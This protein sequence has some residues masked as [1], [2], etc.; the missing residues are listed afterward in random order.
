M[1]FC[2][3]FSRGPA[4]SLPLF[5]DMRLHP[6]IF[7]WTVVIGALGITLENVKEEDSCIIECRGSSQVNFHTGHRYI[8][9]YSTSTST[10]L[11]GSPYGRSGI[12][13]ESIVNIEALGKCH[14][15]LKLQDVQLKTTLASREELVKKMETL[16]KT[17]ERYLLPFSFLD[18]NITK[19]CP[20]TYEEIWAL[21]IKRGILSVLQSSLKA[22]T[23]GTVEE[24]DVLG[25][26]P[27]KYLLK[28]SI[29]KKTKDLNLCSH[30]S[31]SRSSLWSVPLPDGAAQQH[32][33]ES[34]LE[35]IQSLKDKIPVQIACTET[36]LFTPFSKRGNGAKTQ[37]HSSLK[38]LKT[39][40]T[41]SSYMKDIGEVYVSNLLYE[42]EE[43]VVKS[44]GEEVAETVRNLC[45]AQS[46]HF[47]TADL[48]MKL[49]F[50]LRHLSADAMMDL[51]QTSSFKCR[52]NWQPLID[53]LP[54]CGTEACVS[55]MKE[56]LLSKEVEEDQVESF[57]WSLSFI[58]QPTSGMIGS[59]APLLQSPEA[60]QG[61]FLGVTALVHNFCS[62]HSDCALVPELQ[63]VM[64]TLQGYLKKNC[65]IQ[66]PELMT[67]LNLVL[68]A[69]GNAGLAAASLSPV[70]SS[71]A[72]L[73]SNPL[74]IRVAA[75]EAFR[76]IPCSADRT[77]LLQ[78]Y[79]ATEENAELRISSY[80]TAMKCPSEDLFNKVQQ[81]L[82]DEKSSQV[83]SFVWSHL[84]ELLET[85]DPLKA[86]LRDSLPD[87]ILSKE[88]DW[89][90]WKYSS[91]SD[92]TFRAASGGANME[93]SV[94]FTPA[95][96]IPRSAM[97]NLT[98]HVMGRAINLLEV[99]I[100]LENAETLIKKLFGHRSAVHEY[101]SM[102]SEDGYTKSDSP[103][104]GTSKANEKEKKH[105]MRHYGPVSDKLKS[106]TTK[107]ICPSGKYN[108]MNDLE[109]KFAKGMGSKKELKCGLSLKIFGNELRF[110]DCED[111]RAEV[112]RHSLNLA[113]LTLKFLKGQE[114]QYSKR[115][116][117]ATE[118]LS[119][120]AISGFPVQLSLIAS[121]ATK[122]KIKGN[123]DFKRQS[124][125]YI[126]GYIKPSALIQI[127]AQ[128]GV[129]GALGQAGLKWVTR[130]RTS[131]SLDGGVQVKKGRELKV[132]LNTPEESMEIIDFS[133]KLYLVSLVGTERKIDL[134][135]DC[136]ETKTCTS[137]EVSKLLG[138]QFCSEMSYPRSVSGLS[139]PL[140]G[141][142][143]AMLILRK[144][145]K[146]LQQFLL[147][148]RYN[149]IPQ[150]D[151][152]I[153]NEAVLHFFV[154]TPKSYLKREIGVDLIF[155]VP[156]KKFRIQLVHPRKKIQMEGK[157]EAS[158]NS[159]IGHLEL[160][161]DDRDVYYIKGV[162]G[163]QTVSGEQRY[164]TQLEVKLTK[165]GNPIVL[166]G[167][168]T[169]R[170]GKKLSFSLALNNLLKDAA[171]LSV[172]LEKK[173]DDKLKQYSLQGEAYF[174][175]VIGTHAIGLLQ[176]RGSTWSN[177]LR[178]KYGLLGNAKSLRHE[179]DMGQKIKTDMSSTG[180]YKL[181]MEHELHC[182]QI[183]AFN[184]KVQLQ[185]EESTAHLASQLEVN[186]GRHWDERNNRRKL[187]LSQT[188]KNDSDP[189][190]TNYF[191]EFTLQIPE[192]QVDYRT[193]L[194][195]MY[196][197]Q[198]HSESDTNLKVHYNDHIPF[199]AGLRW[200]DSSKNLL[201]KWE[202]TFSVD[203]PW[204]YLHTACTMSQPQRQAY[205]STIELSAGKALS[206]K[207][208]VVEMF[209]KGKSNGKEGRIHIY[210]PSTTY[211]KAST[212]N[213]IERNAFRSYSEVVS[214]WN[215]LL[216]NE[217]HFENNERVKSFLFKLRSA[218][219]EFNLTADYVN[220]DGPKRTNASVKALWTESK[221][222]PIA[223]QLDGQI[224]ELR[225]DKMFYQKRGAFHFRHPFKLP[226]PQSL[227][228]QETFT[229]DKKKSHYLL[230]T[231]IVV[232]GVEESIQT[233]TLGYQA[234]N[235]YNINLCNMKGTWSSNNATTSCPKGAQNGLH[236]FIQ[237]CAGLAHPYNSELFPQNLEMCASVRSHRTA[238]HELEASLKV[239]KKDVLSF[240]GQYQNKS[241]ERD[242]QHLFHMDV[243]HPYQLKFP[244]QLAVDAELFCKQTR[245]G[246]FDCGANGKVTV[247][248]SDTAQFR[249]Q[250]NGTANQVGFYSQFTHPYQLPIFQD[251]RVRA[252]ARSYGENSV[253]GTLFLCCEGKDL[254]V[255]EIDASDVNRKA[256]RTIGFSARM[257]QTLLAQP[258]VVHVR[259]TGRVFPSRISVFSE[260]RLNHNTFLLAF[261]GSKGQKVGL[262]LSFDG[263]VQ[264]N[265]EGL[266]AVPQFLALEG[267]LKQKNHINEGNITF[268]INRA[269][270]GLHVRNRNVFGNTSLH[271]IT[272][273][274][275]QNGSQE[276][277][278]KTELKGHLELTEVMRKGQGC[279]EVD[280]YTL[281]VEISHI[282]G[283]ENQGITGA[284]THNIGS[285]KYT[286][287]PTQGAVM[288]TYNQANANSTVTV[289][290]QS[291]SGRIDAQVEMVRSSAEFSQSLFNASWKHNVGE[292]RTHGIPFSAEGAFYTQDA[293]QKFTA[294]LRAE[295]EREHFRGEIRKKC[296]GA[297]TEIDLFLDHS[298]EVLANTLPSTLQISCTGESTH[299]RLYA[300]CTGE[301]E[302]RLLQTL[303]PT[304]LSFNGSILP[305]DCLADLMG[306]VSSSDSFANLSLRMQCGNQQSMEIGF[307]HAS[308]WLQSLGIAK[309]NKVKMMTKQNG[310]KTLLDIALG[311]CTFK[312]DGQA[313]VENGTGNTTNSDWA[314]SVNHKC[315]TLKDLGI[316]AEMQLGGFLQLDDCQAEFLSVLTLGDDFACFK[317]NAEF[318]PE[319]KVE[320]ELQHEL[321]SLKGIPR[322]SKLSVRVG[323]WLKHDIDVKFKLGKCEFVAMGDLQIESM[324]QWNMHLENKCKATQDLGLPIKVDGSGS[325]VVNKANLDSQM[326]IMIDEDMVRGLLVVKI[327]DN[328]RE[329][330]A[331]LT[332]NLQPAA[333]LGIP[334]RTS[335]NVTSERNGD[336]Y[337]RFSQLSV[338]SK[339]ITEELRFVQEPDY[340]SLNYK[341]SHNLGT[342][343]AFLT[344]DTMDVEAMLDLKDIKHLRMRVQYGCHLI[345]AKGEIQSTETRRA[346]S[347]EFQQNCTWMLQSGI[348][349]SVQAFM[350]LHVM[351]KS[352][353]KMAAGEMSITYFIIQKQ[354]EKFLR[355]ADNSDI[356]LVSGSPKETT[357]PQKQAFGLNSNFEMNTE[358][359]H[360]VPDFRHLGH[361]LTPQMALREMLTDADVKGSLNLSCE[362][363]ISF[364][365]TVNATNQQQ[366]G[367]LDIRAMQNI[368]FLLRF[369][370][371]RAEIS[372][373]I[374]Y[375]MSETEG[376]FCAR[377]DE[378]DICAATKFIFAESGYTKVIEFMHSF[379]QLEILP[380]QLEVMT[381]YQ[382]TDR[383]H[384][385]KHVTLWESKEIKLTG[386]YTGL[387]PKLSG[388]HEVSVEFFHP[389]HLSFPWQSKFNICVEHS[390]QSH[391][392]DII[393]GWNGKNQVAFSSTLIIGQ[394]QLD[395]RVNLTHPF[396][397]AVKR[398]ELSSLS[399]RRGDR[400]SQQAQIAWNGGQPANL[401]VSFEE[402]SKS[403]T[404][405]WE[406]CTTVLS[407]QLQRMLSLGNLQACGSVEQSTNSLNGYLDLS[408]DNRKVKQRLLYEK[409]WPSDP[410][411][412]QL[413]T[414]LENIFLT[415]C[416]EQNIV[417]KL[418]TN[419][420]SWMRHSVSLD[421]CDLPHPVVVSG[422][423]QLNRQEHRLQSE[424]RLRLSRQRN[425]D[426]VFTVTLKN[427]GS[428]QK[429]NC[430]LALD[431]KASKDVQVGLR[432]SYMSSALHSHILLEGDMG[433]KEKI[434]LNMTKGKECLLGHA[435][436][437][438][439]DANEEGI[440]FSACA[441]GKQMASADA[442][443]HTRGVK[444]RLGQI[445]LVAT[446]Q[447]LSLLAQGCG[448]S[449][450]HAESLLTGIG[451]IVNIRFVEMIK[452]FENHFW[453][454]QK[455][456]QQIDFLYETADWPLKA[457][458]EMLGI[459]QN[460][461][462]AV[463]ELWG[464]SGVRH[465]VKNEL[466]VYFEKLHDIIQQ[467]QSELHKPLSAL[468]DAYY[469]VT[470]KSLDE[471]WQ[472]KM[473]EY[474]KKIQAFLPSI[475][476]DVWLKEP[477]GG[478]VTALKISI[479]MGTRQL[480]KWIDTKLS[481]AMSLIWRPLSDLYRYSASNCSVILNL[482]M[483]DRGHQPRDLADISNYLI[484]EKLMKPFRNLYS[485][486][487][488]AEYYL[489]KRR[490]M[491]SP[492][493][494]Q[495]LLI[496]NKHFVTF[497][498]KV[499]S[500]TSKCSLLL[501]HDFAYNSFS[502]VLN[503]E[504]HGMRS[505][506][507]RM[508]QTSIDLYPGGKVE[509]DCQSFDLP[510]ARNGVSI[511]KD[512]NKIEVSSVD[513]VTLICDLQFT[514]CSFTLDGWLHGISAGLFGT[515]DNE[516]RN[517][518]MLPDHLYTDSAQDF[519][520]NWQVNSQCSSTRVK[521]KICSA[522][523][524]TKICKTLFQ[525]AHSPLRNCFRVVDSAPFYNMCLHDT[526]GSN[527]LK[528]TCSLVAAFIHLCNRNFVP[529][530]MPYQCA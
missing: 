253:N 5:R 431:L 237:I 94:I 434:M 310:P 196:F 389:F 290:L 225:K 77:V 474:Q 324:L 70:L 212:V 76:R 446:N 185:H 482:P 213:H 443:L 197:L 40:A 242:L 313:S 450:A 344:E 361:Q 469:D 232:N 240:L 158:R 528:A 516:A 473:I 429:R 238:K 211:L 249:I 81:T 416:T 506:Y 355:R 128:M 44:Q 490:M 47:E 499:Y 138:W 415:S 460:G 391:R 348:P 508:N 12:T 319:I 494:Y 215:Q 512:L 146:G 109:Q 91:F 113:E 257:Q 419:Y 493:E 173:V 472:E 150:K 119:F 349:A 11:E 396:N 345:T 99:G 54:S 333:D 227:L 463:A 178:I 283:Q 521:S 393:V 260:T 421:F 247:N 110:L 224:E 487:P 207:N 258:T 410:D 462:K 96:F 65:T 520:Q 25:S 78:L 505:L 163:L 468:K 6:G 180:D 203:T 386:I 385:V 229:V 276:I 341:L 121:G 382:K 334:A 190:R 133:S 161:L 71:C 266:T 93:T 363:N 49:V 86:H 31:S 323:K 399:E 511:K 228:L 267:F 145:D 139:F 235:P 375:S 87:D 103:T 519:T 72:R 33:L 368:P 184:H 481:R 486:N 327:T 256:T 330:D 475:L 130:I 223:L 165:Q 306:Y 69:I 63:T 143:K 179:C 459:F 483:L 192:K 285:L 172:Q 166:S 479:D 312:A 448:D 210:T 491:E 424:I 296:E 518:F 20:S 250:L 295:V 8:Y 485:I 402:K 74:A 353:V 316:P 343:V 444:E 515:N 286:G 152:W 350:S 106:K 183:P 159:W 29:L 501:A 287:I 98:V 22:T 331:L 517:E 497:D 439:G 177:V 526:C 105:P 234:E 470:L 148:A 23:Q 84:S 339:Q 30:R 357:M 514:V 340:V 465:T 92:F 194:Q 100:R 423:H 384:V 167:N 28:N 273:T 176:Q 274:L 441:D 144:Q 454:I 371:G 66:K 284:L 376:K 136:T 360:S 488:M 381:I 188:F 346:I 226:V 299:T 36:H 216:K 160:I 484:E 199:T 24:V 73:R 153:P 48:F 288:V 457:S 217:I 85:D 55:L 268:L 32:I 309:E 322:E 206:I 142:V 104:E 243:T 275:T 394:E 527:Q 298:V 137:E 191:M 108:K 280:G 248:R 347:G 352:S 373:K 413:E 398:L 426:T 265:L 37:T 58:P 467:I 239:N 220:L 187:F 141:P 414:K 366:S 89:E 195:H 364:V 252:T 387:F 449:F 125:F 337:Q 45:L 300:H 202:G 245:L 451:S 336:L 2:K 134:S 307:S 489:F 264:H 328:K 132:F 233:I 412:I 445:S 292:L 362:W 114:V 236:E 289:A 418:E 297:A 318:Q 241:S 201:M 204:L 50:D 502:I 392:D 231:R 326:L 359:K 406:A 60:S 304:K 61:I 453:K 407:G 189:S 420:K 270:Y 525:E 56:I 219:R 302:S 390:T 88:F 75:V 175:G 42:N 90:T 308:L 19:I 112:R 17:L 523:V 403:N 218:K 356:L 437:F 338:D 332:H 409:K 26:C 466:P 480:M 374:S 27:T 379:P 351:N 261:T 64:K 35:C 367:H 39:E 126:N 21:N 16:K 500:G 442:Y 513:G 259:L 401:T 169:K 1:P 383:A 115:L 10:F 425:E 102:K 263:K 404:T 529:L 155:N 120:P 230:E 209:C 162:T 522:A 455:S 200:K 400:Y 293:N 325:F 140:S 246:D 118:E 151:S 271:N 321:P 395:C 314:V 436:F 447:S 254:V 15:V 122:L 380:G 174:P 51:W 411:K 170:L 408:W 509:E 107:H 111:L 41:A 97:A 116:S 315:V 277:P 282:L 123:V 432:G 4:L 95:S 52:D 342:A 124:D 354:Y 464:Q 186:Y 427:D 272:F 164:T 255:L 244:K 68:K 18:G 13:L 476:K 208:L 477:I 154:G 279:F 221:M 46:M 430:S 82:Q 291:D 59:L 335:V 117:L 438:K 378:K 62:T 317:A 53:A 388:S 101:F 358:V 79:Q 135:K 504:S 435:S 157:I 262:V 503:Q 171:H 149:Y 205:Q 9:K 43:T 222:L 422:K 294:G 329:L 251:V 269:L 83:G 281:C 147:E 498:G 495:A 182:T 433:D 67:E 397:L 193:Q 496:G 510:F 34:K 127:S 471:V 14:L 131:T 303:V 38:L 492:F 305:S 461:A 530:E 320:M 417:G 311:N 80:Y 278:M 129:V 405:A 372:T 440:E 7:L 156:Q 57:L 478:I 507:V 370:P 377:L 452:K 301:T 458:Q 198:G 524:H 168:I 181:D 428:A 365:N 214:L 456:V 369:L 3:L